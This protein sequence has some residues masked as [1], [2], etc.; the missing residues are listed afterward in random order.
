MVTIKICKILADM[1]R[2]FSDL[3]DW[4]ANAILESIETYSKEKDIPIGD[5]IQPI[6]LAIS[7]KLV[8]PPIGESL[9]CL[10]QKSVNSRLQILI[11]FM[12]DGISNDIADIKKALR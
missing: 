3:D 11:L 8:S 10:G 5:V 6:R 1:Y 7:G 9:E 4:T 2:V 12:L